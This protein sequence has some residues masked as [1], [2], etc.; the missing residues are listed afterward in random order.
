MAEGVALDSATGTSISAMIRDA[1]APRQE[2]VDV[3]PASSMIAL[4]RLARHPDRSSLGTKMAWMSQRS[5]DKGPI[6]RA[7]TPGS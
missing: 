3:S 7:P 5:S 6:G 1:S 2:D 4:R